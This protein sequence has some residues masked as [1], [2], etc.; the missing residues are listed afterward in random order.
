MRVVKTPCVGRILAGIG[1]PSQATLIIRLTGSQ[2]IAR[3]VTRLDAELFCKT[4][5]GVKKK[6]RL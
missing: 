3:G 6:Y 2:A 5:N 1:D 4:G